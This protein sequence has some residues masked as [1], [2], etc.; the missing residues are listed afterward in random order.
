MFFSLSGKIILIGEMLI[1]CFYVVS[2]VCPQY[3]WNIQ[4]SFAEDNKKY[5]TA[6]NKPRLLL[7][8]WLVAI[9]VKY[10]VCNAQQFCRL[11]TMFLYNGNTAAIKSTLENI[12]ILKQKQK[13]C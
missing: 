9:T 1:L 5:P 6:C 13:K 7:H 11:K 8:T 4:L 12:V 2:F 3:L 10:S